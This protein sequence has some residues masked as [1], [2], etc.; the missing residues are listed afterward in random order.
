MIC[1]D[2][3]VELDAARLEILKKV[4]PAYGEAARPVDLFD[5]D[6]PEIFVLP[7]KTKFGEWTLLALFNYAEAAA[8]E[9]HVSLARLRFGST[10]D[11]PGI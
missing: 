9:K 7:V 11:V 2:R 1:G 8:A 3:L 4:F 5:C 6:N 10:Q